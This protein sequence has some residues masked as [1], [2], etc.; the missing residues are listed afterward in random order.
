[1]FSV[2]RT[3]NWPFVAVLLN[4]PNLSH[5]SM[6]VLSSIPVRSSV[7]DRFSQFFHMLVALFREEDVVAPERFS[8]W[9]PH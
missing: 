5:Q 7:P 6:I 1:M 4:M 9:T 2:H 8:V 3:V